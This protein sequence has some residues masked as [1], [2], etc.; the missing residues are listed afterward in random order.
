M[1]D[2]APHEVRT[3][4]RLYSSSVLCFRAPDLRE[5]DGESGIEYVCVCVCH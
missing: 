3:I 2:L 1:N 4:G 5:T